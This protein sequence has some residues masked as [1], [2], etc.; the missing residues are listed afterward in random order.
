MLNKRRAIKIWLKSLAPNES[1][2][3]IEKAHLPAPYRQ[4]LESC[5]VKRL[6]AFA[7]IEEL[8]KDNIYIGY[9]SY[10][11]KLAE[12]LDM[13]SKELEYRNRKNGNN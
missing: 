7:A 12:A 10:V 9:W 2:E 4:I 3:I 13:M 11:E 5:C 6:K 1:L 8:E